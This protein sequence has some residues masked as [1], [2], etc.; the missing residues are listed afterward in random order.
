MEQY[1]VTV[2]DNFDKDIEDS[3]ETENNEPLLMVL[4]EISSASILN[5]QRQVKE[6]FQKLEFQAHYVRPYSSDLR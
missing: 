6:A 3:T 2:G 5:L 1:I 4:L